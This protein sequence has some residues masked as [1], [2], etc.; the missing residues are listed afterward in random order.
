MLLAYALER[1]I[2]PQ[3]ALRADLQ[4]SII[5]CCTAIRIDRRLGTPVPDRWALSLVP[6]ALRVPKADM[7]S[8]KLL[9]RLS[10]ADLRL[11]QPHLEAVELPM[12]RQLQAPNKRV[13]HVYFLDEGVASVVANGKRPIEIGIIGREGMT[14]LSVILGNRDRITHEVYMQIAGRGQRLAAVTLRKAIAASATLHQVLLHNV[15]AF[16]TQITQ[17]ALANARNSI[18]ERLARWLL[19]ARDRLDGDEV[20]LTQEFLAIMLGVR[21][22]RVTTALQNLE[23]K[24]LIA[25][26]RARI[27]IMDREGLRESSNG[28][29]CPRNDD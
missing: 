9:D 2:G 12:R 18:E 10:R 28:A 15:H 8:N 17:T 25:H 7:S 16:L 20:P 22:P 23:R 26:Q 19:M 5:A 3:F 29:Y 13:G 4:L 14:G 24:G 27:T 1:S 6:G 11:L 21:R